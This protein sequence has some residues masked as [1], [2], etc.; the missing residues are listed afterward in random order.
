MDDPYEPPFGGTEKTWPDHGYLPHYL[1]IAA[2]LGMSARVCE[3]G[4]RRGDSLRLWQALFPQGDIAGVDC[5]PDAQWPKGTT[6]IESAQ[7]N[8]D[9]PEQVGSRDLIVDD[10]SHL[11]GTTVR[12]FELL[13]P[14]VSPGGYYVIEDWWFHWGL[15]D[16]MLAAVQSLVPLLGKPEMRVA[17]ITYTWGL[18]MIRKKGQAGRL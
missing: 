13:W 1:A 5:D 18:V 14:L 12:S 16:S 11:G 15:K 6:R 17:S 3:L 7:D 4:V 9:R 10:A 2:D 8:P